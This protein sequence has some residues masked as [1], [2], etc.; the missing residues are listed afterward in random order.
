V[1]R[2]DRV[3][4][5]AGTSLDAMVAD[6]CARIDAGEIREAPLGPLCRPP[7]HVDRKGAPHLAV[8]RDTLGRRIGAY[9]DASYAGRVA[10]AYNRI[11]HHFEARMRA[12]DTA[13][14][15]GMDG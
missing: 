12:Q 13:K 6:L 8:V 1:T 14:E 15:D 2:R 10:D 11:W 9:E 4:A 5:S 3:A 7:V